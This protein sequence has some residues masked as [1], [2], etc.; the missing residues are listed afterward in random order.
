MK[1]TP[2]YMPRDWYWYVGDDLDRVYSSARRKFVPAND[3]QFLAWN[4][5]DFEATRILNAVELTEV[6]TQAGCE[7]CAEGLR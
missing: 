4:G 6:L 3:E 2:P 1:I 5:P 7:E